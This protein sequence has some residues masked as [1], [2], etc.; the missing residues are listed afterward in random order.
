MSTASIILAII[1]LLNAYI[2][3]ALNR[4]MTWQK[5]IERRLNDLEICKMTEDRFRKIMQEELQAFEL[6]L[7][8][9]GRL[10]VS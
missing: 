7:I 2:L 1:G 8:K 10:D 5:D 3:V 9:E 6:R 4:L